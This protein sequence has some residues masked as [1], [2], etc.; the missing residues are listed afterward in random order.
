MKYHSVG[1]V[2]QYCD[3]AGWV[4]IGKEPE[5]PC[6]NSPAVGTL[7]EDGTYYAG[8][9]PDGNV[10]MFMASSS[11]EVSDS[12]NDGNTDYSTT[13]LTSTTDGNGNT[14][15]LV[16]TDSDDVAGGVQPHNAANYC[17]GLSAHGHTDWYLPAE[18]ELNLFWN[19]GAP[20]GNVR[21]S[22]PAWYWSSTESSNS[23]AR[24]QRFD[25]GIQAASNKELNVGFYIR[26]VRQQP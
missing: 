13:N 18:D 22:F 20:I 10:P 8:L 26:C 23:A 16:V 19:G 11:T 24:Q 12:W 14:A 17:D 1:Q 7:C 6:A 9:S 4:A 25:T 5:D 21:V 2:M 3:G 15:T